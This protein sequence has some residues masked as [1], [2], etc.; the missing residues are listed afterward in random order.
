MN[1][2]EKIL[3]HHISGG[4]GAW[5]KLYDDLE[6]LV[7]KVGKETLTNAANNATVTADW[8]DEIGDVVHSVDKGSILSETN[9]PKL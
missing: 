2:L 8:D 7:N 1:R 3:N 4:P 9:I 6:D 5:K